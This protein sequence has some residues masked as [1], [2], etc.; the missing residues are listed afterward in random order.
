MKCYR[1]LQAPEGELAAALGSFDGL[2]LGHRQ[3]IGNTL[4]SPNLRPAVVTFQQNPSASLEKKP[5]PILTT[6]EQKLALLE[7]MG[8]DTVYLLPFDQIRDMEPEE[9]VE[10]LYRVCRVRKLCC[11]FNFRFGKNGR[12]DAALLETLCRQWN[13]QLCVVPPVLVGGEPVSSTRIRAA[14][15]QGDVQQAGQLLGRPFGYDFTVTHGR[16]LGRTWGTPT[17]NQP[18]PA[19]YVLPRFGVYASLVTVAG[20]KYYGVTDI[21]VKP[22]VGS[23]CALSETWIP[24]F[25]GN[26]YGKPVPVEL[27][28]FIRPERKFDSL[29]EL[30]NE[31]LRNSVMARQI[32][33]R[34]REEENIDTVNLHNK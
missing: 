29:D 22:T 14:L 20:K 9:F 8:V 23:D 19:G 25:S 32:A 18:F 3:V 33:E 15:E 21:G 34:E 4:S 28:D 16:Q 31:I 24:E 2:H 11:G 13:I 7:E 27:L 10:V 5:V 12:G 6:N 30:K 26:L 1:E 17:I